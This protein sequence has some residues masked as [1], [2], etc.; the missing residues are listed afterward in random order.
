MGL[1][2]VLYSL[3]ARVS[4]THTMKKVLKRIYPDWKPNPARGRR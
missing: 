4:T 1:I 3:K 2:N